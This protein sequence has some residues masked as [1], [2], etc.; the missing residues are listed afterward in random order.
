MLALLC[1]LSACRSE[2]VICTEQLRRM[3][4]RQ[5]VMYRHVGGCILEETGSLL[6]QRNYQKICVLYNTRTRHPSTYGKHTATKVALVELWCD[7][8]VHE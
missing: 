1:S 8:H 3:L 4:I 5:R 6:T 7:E 2:S